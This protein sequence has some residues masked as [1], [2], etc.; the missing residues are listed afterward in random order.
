MRKPLT[1]VI[2][3]ICVTYTC[4]SCLAVTVFYKYEK[5]RVMWCDVM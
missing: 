3:P 5:V 2:P 4:I 1:T